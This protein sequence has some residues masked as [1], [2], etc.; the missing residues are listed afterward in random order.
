MYMCVGV[1]PEPDNAYAQKCDREVYLTHG[2]LLLF[3]PLQ[4]PLDQPS[5]L[6]SSCPGNS[7]DSDSITRKDLANQVIPK[8][9]PMWREI[10]CQLNL[11][12]SVLNEIRVNCHGDVRE[13]CD[14][15]MVETGY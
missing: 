12:V 11:D 4:L 3:R 13:C 10:G 2:H 15:G 6:P 14:R 9:C 8:V 5:P 7:C 1:N